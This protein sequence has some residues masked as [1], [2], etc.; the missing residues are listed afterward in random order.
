MDPPGH[1]GL[2]GT[3]RTA[4]REGGQRG[5]LVPRHGGQQL[6]GQL[7]QPGAGQRGDG[8]HLQLMAPDGLAQPQ[9]DDGRLVLWLEA[10]QQHGGRLLQVGVADADAAPGHAGGQ[11]LLLLGRVRAG[12]HV[13]VV[14]VQGHSRELGV[15]V[16]VLQGQPTADQNA[17]AARPLI[18]APCDAGYGASRAASSPAAATA[19]ACGQDAGT[20]TPASSRTSGEVS[21]SGSVA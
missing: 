18:G 11:E 16:G 10:G 12:P 4:G 17:D 6:A 1:G 3:G 15:G 21:R 2:R 8:E 7:D 9:E 20:S 13:D 5:G 19:S 14:G